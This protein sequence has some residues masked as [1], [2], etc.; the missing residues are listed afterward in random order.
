MHDLSFTHLVSLAVSRKSWSDFWISTISNQLLHYVKISNFYLGYSSDRL[1]YTLTNCISVINYI[2]LLVKHWSG[3][4]PKSKVLKVI[5]QIIWYW[6]SIPKHAD[7]YLLVSQF[8]YEKRIGD[9]DISMFFNAK[10]II[11]ND[12]EGHKTK[13]GIW[14]RQ[15]QFTWSIQYSWLVHILWY[16]PHENYLFY[17]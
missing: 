13:Y 1:Y 17:E 14:F 16:C 10:N 8:L 15:Y 11:V 9:F 2:I 12:G 5:G 3:D 4:V 6:Q 7:L